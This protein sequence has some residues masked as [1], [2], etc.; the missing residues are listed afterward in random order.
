M[1]IGSRVQTP[2]QKGI[3]PNTLAVSFL[4]GTPP[5][6]FLLAPGMDSQP[7]AASTMADTLPNEEDNVAAHAV[8][9]HQEQEIEEKTRPKGR[10]GAILSEDLFDRPPP[11]PTNRCRLEAYVDAGRQGTGGSGLWTS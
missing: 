7:E 6:A 11:P 4:L 10:C 1:Y 9:F 8:A 2:G 3:C 5:S